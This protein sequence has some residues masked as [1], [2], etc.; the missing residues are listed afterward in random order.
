MT[1]G[2]SFIRVHLADIVALWSKAFPKSEK[3]AEEEKSR[4]NTASWIIILD[5]RAGALCGQ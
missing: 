5:S 3:E 2:T 1:L 4:G